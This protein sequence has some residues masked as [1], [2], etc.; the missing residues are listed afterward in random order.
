MP[1]DQKPRDLAGMVMSVLFIGIGAWI[2]L[3]SQSLSALGSVFPRTIAIVLILLS[4]LLLAMNLRRARHAPAPAAAGSREST[5]RR[6]SLVAVM[7]GWSLLMPVI[8]FFV[9]GVLAFAALLVVA[10]YERW[11]MRHAVIYG[12]TAVVTVAGFYFLM[13]DI[14]LIPVPRGMLF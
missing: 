10:E 14:L 5:P 2:L 1:N 7:V 6:L 3:E 13:R 4:L 9:S 8:G 11:T 12:L